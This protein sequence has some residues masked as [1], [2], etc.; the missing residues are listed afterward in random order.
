MAE[1]IHSFENGPSAYAAEPGMEFSAQRALCVHSAVAA[2][3]GLL[4]WQ[5]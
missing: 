1:W 3:S 2:L 4:Q 5:E